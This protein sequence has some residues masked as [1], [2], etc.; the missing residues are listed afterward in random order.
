M[1]HIFLPVLEIG[2][3]EESKLKSMMPATIP[4]IGADWLGAWAKKAIKEASSIGEVI[5]VG[6]SSCI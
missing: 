4:Q 6:D 1:S 5:I 2:D 3:L